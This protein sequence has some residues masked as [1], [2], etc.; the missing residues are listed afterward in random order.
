MKL[1]LLNT[2]AFHFEMFG[3][4]IEYCLLK[5]IRLDIF[6]EFENDLGWIKFYIFNYIPGNENQEYDLNK[7]DN[8]L[9]RFYPFNVFTSSNDYT[10]VILATDDDLGVPNEI[11]NENLGKWILIRFFILYLKQKNAHT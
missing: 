4:I 11:I 8:K 1:A 2:F 9:I 5:N 7:Q 10:K 6:T 3:H